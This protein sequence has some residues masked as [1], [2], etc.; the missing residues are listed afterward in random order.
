M[1]LIALIAQ[2]AFWSCQREEVVDRDGSLLP[3][4]TEL[5]SDVLWMDTLV[6]TNPMVTPGRVRFDL[7]NEPPDLSPGQVFVYPAKYG[8][9]GKV[10]ASQRFDSRIFIEYEPVKL[11]DLFEKLTFDHRVTDD[12]LFSEEW[13]AG[14]ELIGDTTIILRYNF[15]IDTAQYPGFLIQMSKARVK[16]DPEVRCI[17]Q[18]S[19]GSDSPTIGRFQFLTR[20][21]VYSSFALLI[22]VSGACTLNDSIL[23]LTRKYGPF[24]AGGLPVYYQQDIWMGYYAEFERAGHAY[25]ESSADVN[26]QQES[27]YSY[28][29]GWNESGAVNKTMARMDSMYRP[30]YFNFDAAL[31]FTSSWSAL[32]AGDTIGRWLESISTSVYSEVDFP[33]YV[34]GE[35]IS[36]G[37]DFLLLGDLLKGLPITDRPWVNQQLYVNSNQGV[38]QNQPPRALFQINPPHGYIA[39]LF[40][41]N[42]STSWDIE[43]PTE[44][45]EFR[46]D[47][48]G[49]NI[50]D[51]GFTANPLGYWQY[52]RSGVYSV[53][54][55]VRDKG[56]LVSRTI[57][58]LKVEETSS[59]PIAFFTI[60][61]ESGRT[62]N[63]FIFDASGSTDLEDEVALLKVRWD[64]EDDG[65]WDTDF[66]LTKVAVHFY[67]EPGTYVIKLEVKD[68]QGLTGSTTRFLTVQAANVRPTAYFEVTPLIGTTET[69]FYFNGSGSS[70]PEDPVEEL[71]VRWDWENNGVWDTGYR[72]EKTITHQFTTAGTFRVVMEVKDTEALTHT[73]GTNIT[74][75]NPNLAPTADFTISPLTGT[76]DTE[77]TFDASISTDP[78]GSIEA[79]QVRWDWNNDEIYDTEYTTEKVIRKR[80]DQTGTYIIKLMV[81]DSGGLTDTKARLL[82]IN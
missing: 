52:S 37:S 63:Y 60:T 49:D 66:V 76:I 48:N 58:I 22:N 11:T 59:A 61:P 32:V 9:T 53:I 78:E 77:Y 50:F 40:E 15:A 69:V 44:K 70:D 14:H 1:L 45:L 72:Y 23:L 2:M 75:T 26:S 73:V 31:R 67:R 35:N 51:T 28:W 55:E 12:L 38:Y 42:A 16:L 25:I 3:A 71:Q 13:Y 43:D 20:Q 39:T 17:L 27:R 74:V 68:V 33:N 56:G 7:L 41:F 29:S 10:L 6:F 30:S 54:L 79:L 34:N 36:V 4:E 81:M 62:N 47:F 82:H 8:L 57:Q 80:F 5:R 24:S 64:W 19:P 46:W 18:I 65:I 21:E